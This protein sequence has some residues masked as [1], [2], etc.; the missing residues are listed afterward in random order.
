VQT[1]DQWQQLRLF[2]GQHVGVVLSLDVWCSADNGERCVAN[3]TLR[4]TSGVLL[5][6]SGLFE[7]V[8][9]SRALASDLGQACQ[10]M[11]RVARDLTA[12]F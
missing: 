8:L 4:D 3:V 1:T 7:G 9:H 5:E 2:G 11:L 12:P 10:E 6:Q